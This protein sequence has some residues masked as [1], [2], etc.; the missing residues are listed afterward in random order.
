MELYKGHTVSRQTLLL[1]LLLAT[2]FTSFA[3]A[4]MIDVLPAEA[5]ALPGYSTQA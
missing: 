4:G 1:G 2:Q 3:H 5:R